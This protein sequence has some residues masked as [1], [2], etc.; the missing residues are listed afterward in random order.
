MN[1]QPDKQER[2]K[3]QRL[4]APCQRQPLA[5]KIFPCHETK[6]LLDTFSARGRERQPNRREK[7]GGEREKWLSG[8]TQA[9]YC[10]LLPP[11]ISYLVSVPSGMPVLISG[12][13]GRGD[14]GHL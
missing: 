11:P 4:T 13:V 8:R 3:K 12:D 6:K 9:A 10:L 14:R 2:K 7:E 1:I 5:R